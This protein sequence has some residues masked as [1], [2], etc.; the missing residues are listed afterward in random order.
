MSYRTK[1]SMI[2]GGIWLVLFVIFS[3]IFF[4]NNFPAIIPIS[5]Y[6]TGVVVILILANIINIFLVFFLKNKEK[7]DERNRQLAL[8]SANIT[9]VVVVVVVTASCLSLYFIYRYNAS[10]P[11]A[12]L[13]FI[14]FGTMFITNI[15]LNLSYVVVSIKGASYED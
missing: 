2:N 15:V 9:M 7:E 3:I 11:I 1:F 6:K 10:F 5:N 14:G 8:L 13:W 4:S 12:W